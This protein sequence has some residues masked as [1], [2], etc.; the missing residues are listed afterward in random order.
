MVGKTNAKE[1]LAQMGNLEEMLSFIKAF[2]FPSQTAFLNKITL[3]CEEAL[4]NVIRHGY[5]KEK[6][7][8]IWIECLKEKDGI[9][10]NF[11]DLGIPF[12]PES[13]FNKISAKNDSPKSGLGV[14]L[15]MKSADKVS[16]ERKDGKNR[17]SLYFYFN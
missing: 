9:S 12:N 14:R 6:A 1:Y 16:Y 10:I 15:M 17:L 8:T 2:C 4:V 7:G 5:E 3:A 11:I 13:H